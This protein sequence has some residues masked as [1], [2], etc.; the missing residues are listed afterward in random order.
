MS[1]FTLRRLQVTQLLAFR[2]WGADAFLS[3][4]LWFGEECAVSVEA[5]PGAA[6]ACGAGGLSVANIV[7]D[8]SWVHFSVMEMRL[9]VVV[10]G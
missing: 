2:P 1:H 9:D 6:A 4:G 3:M 8:T 10:F 7:L 5:K